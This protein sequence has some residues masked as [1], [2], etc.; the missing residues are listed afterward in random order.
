LDRVP[1]SRGGEELGS[2]GNGETESLGIAGLVL[3]LVAWGSGLVLG[4]P[5]NR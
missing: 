3:V 2:R 4:V 5:M 1:M